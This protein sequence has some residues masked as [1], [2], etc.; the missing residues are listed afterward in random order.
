MATDIRV[1]TL[2]P[3]AFYVGAETVSEI[4]LGDDQVYP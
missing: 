1:G 2:T 3:T 4:Y